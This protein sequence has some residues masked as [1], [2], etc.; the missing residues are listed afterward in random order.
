MTIQAWLPPDGHRSSLID[1]FSRLGGG[2]VW[3]HE[4][5]STHWY[6]VRE[7]LVL[8]YRIRRQDWA[9]TDEHVRAFKTIVSKQWASK[10]VLIE[11]GYDYKDYGEG[12]YSIDRKSTPVSLK[13]KSQSLL[14]GN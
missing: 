2:Y 5:Q 12:G 10:S 6:Y 3:R 4:D 13:I 7:R 14:Y 1:S 9:L 11:A 8:E